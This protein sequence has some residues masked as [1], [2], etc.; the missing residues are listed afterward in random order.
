[1]NGNKLYIVSEG[2][3]EGYVYSKYASCHINLNAVLSDTVFVNINTQ[4]AVI[5][6]PSGE[7]KSNWLQVDD[8]WVPGMK[9]T[10][11]GWVFDNVKGVLG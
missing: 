7:P 8:A 2:Q 11:D 1:M 9:A 6:I 5:T 4:A 10:K 3:L